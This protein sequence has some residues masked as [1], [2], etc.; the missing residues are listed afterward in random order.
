MRLWLKGCLESSNYQHFLIRE[1]TISKGFKQ[2]EPLSPLLFIVAMDGLS[3]TMRSTYDISIFH[4]IN[5]PNGGP[6]TSHLLYSD[7][8]LFLGKWLKQNINNL[9]RILHCFHVSSG[10][11]ITFNKSRVFGFGTDMQEVSNWFDLLDVNPPPPLHLPMGPVGANMNF[12]K[13]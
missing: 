13:N 5:L 2:G 7:D 12:K 11:G 6:S 1:F 9:A 3:V 8:T 4:G 10:L